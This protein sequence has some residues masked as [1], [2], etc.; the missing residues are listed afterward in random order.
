MSGPIASV[1]GAVLPA[2][3]GPAFR[4]LWTAASVI[5]VGDGIVLA[6]G[7]LLVASLTG[8]AFLVSLAVLCEYLPALVVGPIA[9]VVVDRVDRRRIF[10]LV[11]VTRT[12]MIAVLAATVAV[13]GATIWFVLLM[14]LL[15]G[16]AETF[17]DIAATSL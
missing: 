11:N 16:T 14:L 13:G 8:D 5:N 15:L 1:V 12:G 7:P 9:G 17:A 10:I 4:W 6:A 2:R 3:L